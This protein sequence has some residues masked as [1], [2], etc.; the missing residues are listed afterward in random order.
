MFCLFLLTD[1]NSNLVFVAMLK[2]SHK[3]DRGGGGCVES[4]VWKWCFAFFP[5]RDKDCSGLIKILQHPSRTF[6]SPNQ[7]TSYLS[8]TISLSLTFEVDNIHAVK[9]IKP[10][11]TQNIIYIVG[12]EGKNV[13]DWMTVFLLVWVTGPISPSSPHQLIFLWTKKVFTRLRLEMLKSTAGACNVKKQWFREILF[14][15][16][17]VEIY[18]FI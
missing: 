4:V 17:S 7:P 11:L 1:K 10:V 18:H 12:W 3:N 8:S 9:S 2:Q 13:C 6:R 14:H 15:L 16:L 5:S